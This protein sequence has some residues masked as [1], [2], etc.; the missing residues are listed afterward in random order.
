MII[1]TL[2]HFIFLVENRLQ[3]KPS[4]AEI[5]LNAERSFYMQSMVG[6][7]GFEPKAFSV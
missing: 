3:K 1:Q 4:R 2:Y 6:D 7:L 5:I